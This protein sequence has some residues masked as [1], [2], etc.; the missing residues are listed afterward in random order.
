MTTHTM[1][2]TT[3]TYSTKILPNSK[4]QEAFV[5]V[6]NADQYRT[7]QKLMED[8]N[9][10]SATALVTRVVIDDTLYR[11]LET[12][13]EYKALIEEEKGPSIYDHPEMLQ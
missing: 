2:A 1:T 11:L 12:E 13:H 8:D 7:F 9:L 10:G 6:C 3:T 5:K 4:L